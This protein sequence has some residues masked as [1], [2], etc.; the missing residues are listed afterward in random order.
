MGAVVQRCLVP[1]TSVVVPKEE[2]HRLLA[3]DLAHDPATW[4]GDGYVKG[5]AERLEAEKG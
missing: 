3:A 4:V 5:G 2:G 1:R